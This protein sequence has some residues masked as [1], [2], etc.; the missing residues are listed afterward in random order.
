MTFLMRPIVDRCVCSGVT[1]AELKELHD[2]GLSLEEMQAQTGC[3]SACNMCEPYIR[4]MIDSGRTR[5]TPLTS[6]QIA[7]VGTRA[8]R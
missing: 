4:L 6:A 1:F 8:A 2:K 5:F 3:S 7:A